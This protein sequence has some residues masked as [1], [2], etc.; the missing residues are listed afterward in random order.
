[1]NQNHLA[2]ALCPSSSTECLSVSHLACLSKDFLANSSSPSSDTNTASPLIPRGGECR[3]C[4]EYIL[5]GDVIRGC[6]RRLKGGVVEPEEELE[7]EDEDEADVE[8]AASLEE[9]DD[10]DDATEAKLK[11]K[12]GKGKGKSTTAK[13]SSPEKKKTRT[14]TKRSAGSR[15]A[16]PEAGPS[17]PRGRPRKIQRTIHTQAAQQ[18][19]NM[20]Q[21]F[22]SIFELTAS[23]QNSELSD[24]E[25]FDLKAISSD[26]ESDDIPIRL[27]AKPNAQPTKALQPCLN[28]TARIDV[29]EVDFFDLHSDNDRAPPIPDENEDGLSSPPSR[30]F[31]AMSILTDSEN[32]ALENPPPVPSHTTLP[33]KRPRSEVIEVSD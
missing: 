28:P 17:K 2:L 1:M 8:S 11:T 14:S 3:S 6:Y 25:F 10:E 13:A 23:L 32:E 29:G 16:V 7:D 18:V 5:W 24:G 15:A 9:L 30:A 12:K 22:S 4:H 21:A 33:S 26:S 31:S 27:T 19:S 20:P